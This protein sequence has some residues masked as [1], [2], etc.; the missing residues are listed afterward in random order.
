MAKYVLS[1]GAFQPLRS[2][3]LFSEYHKKSV[4]CGMVTIRVAPAPV[5]IPRCGN[6]D[7]FHAE[8]VPESG[9]RPAWYP[10]WATDE[11]SHALAWQATLCLKQLGL[12]AETKDGRAA[13]ADQALAVY[14]SRRC[15]MVGREGEFLSGLRR[16]SRSRRR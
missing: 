11:S 10:S 9:A 16:K 12:R 6:R 8:V 15:G 14:E 4:D 2:R 13:A 5:K 3:F 1:A 7:A